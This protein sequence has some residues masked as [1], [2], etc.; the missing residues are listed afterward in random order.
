MLL[1]EYTPDFK[2]HQ[3]RVKAKARVNANR[4]K[5]YSYLDNH[6]CVCCGEKDPIVLEFDHLDPSN[7]HIA[8]S[9]AVCNGWSWK[10]IYS[11]IEK[12]Q[13]LCANC[14]RRK[15]ALQFEWYTPNALLAHSVE[16]TVYIR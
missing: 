1:L 6:P 16:Q 8:V 10:R 2:K 15:T 7:K 4:I 11:E 3:R 5:L 9:N 12:C 13:V 14:H